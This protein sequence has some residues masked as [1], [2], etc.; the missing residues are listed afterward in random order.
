MSER[1]E[2]PPSRCLS[3]GGTFY[4]ESM[5]ADPDVLPDRTDREMWDARESWAPPLPDAVDLVVETQSMMS[6]L[7]AQ[8]Y[9]RVDAMRC[10]ALADAAA[11]GCPLTD[12][13]E[14][15]IRLELAAALG[16]TEAAADVLLSRADAL[17][18]RYPSVLD[19]LG[20]ARMTSRHA[21]LLVDAMDVV[22]PALREGLL[23]AAVALAE[24]QP[25]GTFRRRL[26]TLIDAARVVTLSD[27][28]AEA[29][30]G[31]RAVLETAD[32]GM[33]W[34]HLLIPVV[35]AHAIHG[36][37]TAIAKVL[38]VHPDETRTLDQLR[39]DIASDLLIDGTTDSLP[40]DARGIRATVA[41]TVP[42]LTL[43]DRTVDDRD[44]DV[45]GSGIDQ[46]QHVTATGSR[47][48]YAS[49]EGVGPIPIERAQEL[50]GA[51]EGWMR[52]L[53]HPETGIVLSVGR[54]QYRPPPA[55][56]CLVRWRAETCMAPGCNVPASRCQIDHN[57]AWEHGGS[58][59]L[60]NLLPFCQGHHTVKHHGR[61]HIEQLEG[62]GGAVQW[63]SP[64]GR[65]YRV[66][67]ECRT[68]TFAPTGE[69]PPL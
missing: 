23:A 17:V 6:I 11:H 32:D 25:V 55:L 20:G 3:V 19:S 67:P 50:C 52:V 24:S 27:R 47:D 33:G 69:P 66:D 10:E 38:A 16:I 61:W 5:F 48:G 44:R 31:R 26:R 42:V 18:N 43:L 21:T 59:A 29:V 41:V 35:E 9:V 46:S 56:R 65:R 40:A 36:R 13:I 62:T 4:S 30:K 37:A 68:P 45:E 39:A 15:S 2:E 14:R 54:D 1:R 63:T 12:V 8:Q 51:A 64:T 57:I 22:E 34:L 60:D 7:T 58:T 53:T 28:Y 49:V